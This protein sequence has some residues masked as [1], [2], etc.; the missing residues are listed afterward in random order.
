MSGS[1]RDPPASC[2]SHFLHQRFRVAE[3]GLV[4]P[5]PRILSIAVGAVVIVRSARK[6]AAGS[7][8]SLA[9]G[10]RA[11]AAA[12]ARRGR[13]LTAFSYRRFASSRLPRA[14]SCASEKQFREVRSLFIRLSV[15]D[16]SQ[17]ISGIGV[18]PELAERVAQADASP[19]RCRDRRPASHAEIARRAAARFCAI[20]TAT[21][22]P[23]G[24]NLLHGA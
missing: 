20:S 14:C 23:S 22:V 10:G 24:A 7:P 11:R 5:Q 17:L 15:D 9:R 3:M 2:F 16:S 13:A 18:A 1:L 12:I 8:D 19:R 6:A 4:V 21:S